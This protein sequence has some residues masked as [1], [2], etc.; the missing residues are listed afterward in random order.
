MLPPGTTLAQMLGE[1]NK[2]KDNPVMVAKVGSKICELSYVPQEGDQIRLLD[3]SSGEG[4][5]AYQRALLHMFVRACR[6]LFPQDR[7]CVQHSMGTGIYCEFEGDHILSPFDLD[8]IQQ[9]MQQY[10]AED[11][12]FV[13]QLVSRQEAIELYSNEQ[14]TDKARLLRFREDKQ[15]KIYTCGGMSDY[16]YG[17]MP[18][19][20]GYARRFRLI[21]HHPGAVLAFPTRQDPCG[22][23]PFEPR[24]KL[25][26]VFRQSERWARILHCSCVADLNEMVERKELEHFILVNE[27]LHE[28]TIADFCEDIC[29]GRKKFV[30]VAGPSSSGKTTFSQRLCIQL[31][32]AGK[33]P[34]LISMD[35]YYIDRDK[36]PLQPDGSVDL[37]HINTLDLDLFNQHLQALLQGERVEIPR[38][39]FPNG[40]CIR[41][42]GRFL[43]L[44]EEDVLL[45]EGI[46]GLNP[47]V[48]Q[49]IRPEEK[50]RIYISA[51]TQL[52]LDHHNRIPTTD[53]RLM[54]RLVRDYTHRGASAEHTLSMWESVRAGENRW[55]FP[56]QEQCD[57]MFNSTLV[58]ELLYLKRYAYP[59][60]KSVPEDSEYFAEANRLVK[61]LN[62]FIDPGSEEMIP[63]TSILREF[64]GGGCF[65]Q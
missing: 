12:P 19:S 22:P 53:V 7:V 65:E 42:T 48:S 6:E 18:P 46:H 54:R 30:F 57:V 29:T 47:Q 38:F 33:N 40:R 21:Y 25:S 58:Y 16:Y 49:S 31:Q 4:S 41:E 39:D 63:R 51:L 37:E 10:A 36:V 34:S 56:Y 8:K 20:T 64:I 55:I 2:K 44:G 45:V 17:H 52:N 43:Q 23:I 15:F 60:L 35:N 28:R 5:R 3:L 9:R 11:L 61:F 24:P 1:E 14:Q 50:F 13:R 26:H 27:A 59:L 62:Y 32:A